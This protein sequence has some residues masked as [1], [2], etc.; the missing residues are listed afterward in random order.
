MPDPRAVQTWVRL[1]RAGLHPGS[2]LKL[3]RGESDDVRFR[4]H[5]LGAADRKRL[6]WMAMRIWGGEYDL[7][8]FV[9]ARGDRVLDLGANVGVYS[10]LAA[11][12][13]ARV[14]ALEPDPDTFAWLARNTAPFAVDCRRGAVVA[15]ATAEVALVRDPRGDTA[16]HIARPGD[17]EG[18]RVP[19]IAFAELLAEGY[20]LV[21]LDVEGAEFELLSGTAP[22]ALAGLR[23]LVAEVHRDAGDPAEPAARLRAAGMEVAFHEDARDPAHVLMTARR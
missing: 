10:V 22:D 19:A 20:D 5:A 9:P 15:R 23:R 18:V 11:A 1:I 14:T 12:R 2:A 16:N 17:P 3:R 6:A 21:K 7:P 13:G 4:G 8:G